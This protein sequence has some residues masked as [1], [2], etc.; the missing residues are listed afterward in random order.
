VF[1]K[2]G[3]AHLKIALVMWR[4]F[5]VNLCITVSCIEE[6]VRLGTKNVAL[7]LEAAFIILFSLTGV[8]FSLFERAPKEQCALAELR[9][10]K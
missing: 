10:Y 3:H 5:S 4:R 9:G 1:K 6:C 8:L 7:T 2:S